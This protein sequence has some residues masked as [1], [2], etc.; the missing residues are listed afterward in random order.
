M[1]KKRKTLTYRAEG[2]VAGVRPTPEIQLEVEGWT[3]VRR[4]M[5]GGREERREGS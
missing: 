5:T 4:R 3:D 2:R 1:K